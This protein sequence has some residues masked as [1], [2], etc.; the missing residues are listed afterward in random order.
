MVVDTNKSFESEINALKEQ[1]AILQL[2]VQSMQE[3]TEKKE[4]ALANLA[5]E[6]ESLSSDLRKQ[7]RS[8]S[9][10]KQQ[11]QEER[12]FYYQEKEK[13]CQEMNDCKRIKRQIA[14]ADDDKSD[15]E[16]YK[17]EI[18]RLKLILNQ[19][20]EANFNL[21]VK[22]LRMK[23]T[24]SFLKERVKLL[25]EEHQKAI[26]ELK[27][28]VQDLKATIKEVISEEFQLPISP[29]HKK[30]LKV[31]FLVVLCDY[32]MVLVCFKQIIKENGNLVHENLCL[33]LEVDSMAMEIEKLKHKIS[34]TDTRNSLKYVNSKTKSN[35]SEKKEKKVVRIDSNTTVIKQKHEDEEAETK[36]GSPPPATETVTKIYERTETPDMPIITELQTDK[37]SVY[38]TVAKTS[39]SQTTKSTKESMPLMQVSSNGSVMLGSENEPI[40]T[41]S[42]PEIVQSSVFS[43]SCK[44]SDSMQVEIKYYK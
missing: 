26:A 23:N 30:F 32:F 1:I 5:R 4:V 22:F 38:L 18:A 16:K 13:Y 2:T 37:S 40:R 17:Q 42:A 35:C 29:S 7:R 10:L 34:R 31:G 33:Q 21:S 25:E 6:K 14:E 39:S 9:N 27:R 19:T 20:L 12:E 28:E 3:E 15:C 41:Q 11:L 36:E 44:S 43:D 8:N 24:K